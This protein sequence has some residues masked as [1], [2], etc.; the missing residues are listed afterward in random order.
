MDSIRP[1]SSIPPVGG[2]TSQGRGQQSQQGQL[3]L[4]QLIKALVVDAKGSDQFVLDIAGNKL[5]AQSQAILTVG[6]TLQLQVANTS[7]QI[8]LK[9]VND[10]LNQFI[11]KSI[12]LIGKNIDLSTLFQSLTQSSTP[13]T[14]LQTLTPTSRSII[15]SF[16]SLQQSALGSKDGGAA[17][18]QLLESVGLNLEHHL[19]RGDKN[20]AVATLKA[21]LLEVAHAF[22]N[23]ET[24]ATSTNQVLNTIELFQLAHLNSSNDTFLIFPLPLPF[25]EAGY[26]TVDKDE[27]KEGS[28]CQKEFRFSLH[29]TMSELGHIHISFVKSEDTLF[30]RFRA[31]SQEKME[32]IQQYTG[33]LEE[34]ITDIDH[35]QISFS[36]DATDPVGDLIKQV[37][38][39]GQSMLDTKA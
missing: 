23:A 26:L 3:P 6:Q 36:D 4:G 14:P 37:V 12:S 29:L 15:E 25:L 16:F 34:A 20:S 24:I 19:A 17:F 28:D 10:T 35:I 11:G 38:P 13:P 39:Q 31:E 9:I 1:L 21:A 27:G 18:K 7:P 30:I 5:A 33:E 2:A 8:E 22:K 32:F